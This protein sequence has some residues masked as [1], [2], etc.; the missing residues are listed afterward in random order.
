MPTASDGT[1]VLHI[2]E[3]WDNGVEISVREYV[4]FLIFETSMGPSFEMLPN[5]E[6]IREEYEHDPE[7]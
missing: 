5:G 4:R 2:A 6:I 3:A 1:E 7:D